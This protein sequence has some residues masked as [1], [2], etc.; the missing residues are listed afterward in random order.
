MISNITC[1]GGGPLIALPSEIAADWRGTLPPI[2]ANVPDGWRWGSSPY[3]E[4]DYDRAC[5]NIEKIG[6]FGYDYF[7]VIPVKE[8]Q[9]II[10]SCEQVISFKENDEGGILIGNFHEY[11]KLDEFL[12]TIDDSKWELYNQPLELKEGK[13][14]I[15][16][17][18]FEGYADAEQ[19]RAFD[20]VVVGN[21]G[22]GKYNVYHQNTDDNVGLLKFVRI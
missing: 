6:R 14:F 16:D 3:I 4:C 8:A 5:G 2:G 7:G 13:L 11:E 9:A 10:F 12:G 18:A 1:S 15:F 17:S 21:P 19:I 20:H 22:A